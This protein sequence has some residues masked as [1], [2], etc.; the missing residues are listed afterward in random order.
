MES[1][2]TLP[3]NVPTIVLGAFQET[4]ISSILALGP[5]S[6]CVWLT[7]NTSLI[8][9]SYN[10][11]LTWTIEC[12][13]LYGSTGLI[14]MDYNVLQLNT[15]SSP[16]LCSGTP[17]RLW[18]PLPRCADT[19]CSTALGRLQHLTHAG[20][21][22]N[23]R[24][25]GVFLKVFPLCPLGEE[26]WEI[27]RAILRK[28]TNSQGE[29]FSGQEVICVVENTPDT[30]FSAGAHDLKHF[31]WK[32][33]TRSFFLMS[34]IYLKFNLARISPFLVIKSYITLEWSYEAWVLCLCWWLNLLL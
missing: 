31:N 15:C 20:C 13:V 17:I 11:W 28:G 23:F 4:A 22:C 33:M 27:S 9:F 19:G 30:D 29:R 8:P 2:L 5:T 12:G 7:W 18:G 6:L 25:M 26:L 3:S 14:E 34:V 32:E 10:G 16:I 1:E 21:L 24:S